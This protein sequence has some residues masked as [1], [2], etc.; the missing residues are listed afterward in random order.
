MKKITITQFFRVLPLFLFTITL[1][2]QIV[3]LKSALAVDFIKFEREFSGKGSSQGAFSKDIHLAFKQ[4]IYV[5]D[6]EN[7]LI[8]KLSPTGEFLGQ[9]PANP[10]APDNILRKPGHL[11]VDE[12]GN[13]YVTDVTAHHIAETADPKIYIFAPCVHKFS[14]IGELLDTYFV[15]PVDERPGVVLPAKLIIDEN[16]KTAFGIQPTGH[17]RALRVAVNAQNQLYILDAKRGRIHQ[18]A[19]D[20]KKLLTFGRYGAGDGEFDKD[21]ADIAIDLRGNV[22]VADT[23]NHR[24]VKFNSDGKFVRNFGKKGRDNGEFVKPMALVTLPTGEILVK[25]ASRFRRKVGGLPEVIALSPTLTQLTESTPGQADLANTITN[26]TRPQYGPFAQNPFTAVDTASLNRRLRLLEEA[27]YRR[28]F[29]D[30]DYDNE[31]DEELAEELKRADIRLTLFHNVISRI[32]KF[33]NNGRYIGRIIYETDQLSEKKHD[34]TFLD[35]DPSGYLYL[36][37]T[38]DFTIAQYSVTG[39]TVKPS[40]MNGFYSTRV[41]NFSNN[42]LEDYEDID[43][44]TDVEDKLNQ[45]ELKN[46]FGWTYSLSE[47]WHLTFLDE[48]TYSEQDERYTT[49]AK[50]EDSFDFETQALENAFAV[51]LKYITNPNPY[52]YKE[53]NLSVGRVDGTSDLTQDALFPDLNKQQR[54]DTGDANSTVIELNWDIWSRT[55]LWLRY[56]DLNPAETSRNFVRRFYDVSGDL[57]EVF[58]SRNQARQFLGEFTI[59]F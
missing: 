18:F 17:D 41:A 53:L 47:R 40:H 55:N 59:K 3:Y 39:F 33:D 58:G 43:F 56:A 12:I 19:A 5:S 52:Q 22:F 44:S 31:N 57:Y 50:L 48:L 21:A 13:I 49:P 2:L 30:K 1:L 46:L 45:L 34:L 42:Y 8:Q 20:G 15:D 54:I 9:I 7:R 36:R 11:T 4:N 10:E 14:L 29:D 6:T 26:A 35:F 24:I 51:N 25:D 16:G 28:Y 23:G 27:E 32:Q 37:D 38:S